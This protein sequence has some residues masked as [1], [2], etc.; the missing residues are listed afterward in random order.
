MAG[1]GELRHCWGTLRRPA[2]TVAVGV[3]VQSVAA[4]EGAAVEA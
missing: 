1:P 4:A 3:A 2:K